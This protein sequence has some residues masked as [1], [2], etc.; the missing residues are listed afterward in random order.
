ML[1]EKKCDCSVYFE[2]Y[3]CMMPVGNF[4]R[5]RLHMRQRL[6]LVDAVILKFGLLHTSLSTENIV[7]TAKRMESSN[8]SF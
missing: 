2:V 8:P 5:F 4:R 6:R 1:D 3:I 7:L